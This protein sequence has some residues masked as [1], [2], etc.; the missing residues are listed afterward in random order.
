[1]GAP[2]PAVAR[3]DNDGGRDRSDEET[4]S[5][6]QCDALVARLAPYDKDCR[7][8]AASPHACKRKEPRAAACE[9]RGVA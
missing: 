5:D 8:V 4:R 7:I 3:G 9:R 1:M 2:E 6:H